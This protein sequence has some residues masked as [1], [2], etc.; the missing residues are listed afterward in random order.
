MRKF[1]DFDQQVVANRR[2]DDG[3]RI[4]H[5]R[6]RQRGPVRSFVVTEHQQTMRCVSYTDTENVTRCP[7]NGDR[8]PQCID[9]R[10]EVVQVRLDDI[11]NETRYLKPDKDWQAETA[12]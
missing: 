9:Q 6:L 4:R 1:A 11:T 10:Q 3:R 2:D 12:Y 7:T 5:V 8:F